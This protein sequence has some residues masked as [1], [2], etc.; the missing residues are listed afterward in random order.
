MEKKK[1]Y[2]SAAYHRYFEGYEE[3]QKCMPDGRVVIERFYTGMYYRQN[4]PDSRR[5]LN[6]GI[7]ALCLLA[8]AELFLY[9]ASRPLPCSNLWYVNIPS[10]WSLVTLILTAMYT[11]LN[12]IAPREMEIH[13][14]RDAHERL[15]AVSRL[16]AAGLV[17]TGAAAA[18]SLSVS[19]GPAAETL[20]CAAQYAVCGI[21]IFLIFHIEKNTSYTEQG[22][23]YPHQAKG[24]RIRYE[25]EF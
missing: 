6:R 21:L 20:R 25:S 5:R 3:L 13:S 19:G 10:V 11:V 24:S 2:H 18:L 1:A 15:I 22:S 16:C 23:R 9:T 14:Y 7:F 12:L 4:I 17:V 8:A